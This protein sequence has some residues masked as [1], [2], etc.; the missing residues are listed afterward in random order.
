MPRH[1]ASII[2]TMEQRE[3]YERRVW[4][5]AYLLS[6]GDE[7]GAGRIVTE[8]VDTR[9][10]LEA[11]EASRLDRLVVLA[12]RRLRS[13][14]KLGRS[15]QAPVDPGI[16][17]LRQTLV[18]PYQSFEAWILARVDGLDEVATGRAMDSSRTAANTHL[19]AANKLVRELFVDHPAIK[20]D[21]QRAAALIQQAADRLNGTSVIDQ[22]RRELAKKRR[23]RKVIVIL[24]LALV[25]V[26]GAKLVMTMLP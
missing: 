21:P 4:R 10:K 7:L 22:C 15:K 16:A 25:A 13:S 11:V 5:L 19:N 1:S 23:I 9:R 17:V 14:G 2:P 20:G 12:A 26:V 18:L 24:V 8:V 3:A 6:G